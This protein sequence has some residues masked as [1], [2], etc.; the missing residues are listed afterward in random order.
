[1]KTQNFSW[2]QGAYICANSQKLDLHN[3]YDFL[4]FTY[5]VEAQSVSLRWRRG[6]G[7]WVDGDQPEKI[8]LSVFDVHYF[9]FVPRDPKM[10]RTEDKCLAS[11]GY[12]SDEDGVD[13]QF[14]TVGPADP[15][16][17]WSLEFQSGAELVVGGSRAIVEF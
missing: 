16:W 10:P 3:D 9:K 4:G 7:D 1:M 8:R 15:G 17:R 11:F 2:S 13:G 6:L 12:D 14:W 5:D